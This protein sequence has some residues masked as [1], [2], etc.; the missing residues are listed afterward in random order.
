MRKESRLFVFLSI[1]LSIC[2][3]GV[4]MLL[5]PL[6]WMLMQYIIVLMISALIVLVIMLMVWMIKIIFGAMY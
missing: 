5:T 2:I 6:K 4:L 3:Y 1:I